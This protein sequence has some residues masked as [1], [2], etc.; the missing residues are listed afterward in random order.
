[1]AYISVLQVR[2]MYNDQG[3]A[4]TDAGPSCAVEVIGWRELPSAGDLILQVKTEVRTL[5]FFELR[6]MFY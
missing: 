5:F 3:K 2:G 1:M 6:K 4:V